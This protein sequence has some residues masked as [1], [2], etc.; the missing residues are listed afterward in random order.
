MASTILKITSTLLI[1]A[2]TV[3]SI[4]VAGRSCVGDACNQSIQSGNVNLGSS[5][6]VVPVTQVTPITRY[7]PIVQSYAPIVQAETVCGNLPF[8]QDPGAGMM[9]NRFRYN[10][11]QIDRSGRF[12]FADRMSDPRFN[13]D[14]VQFGGSYNR[15]YPGNIN[16][17]N[18]DDININRFNRFYLDDTNIHH[19]NLGDVNINRLNKRDLIKSDEDQLKHG[20]KPECVPSATET[21]EQNLPISTTDMGSNVEVKPSNVI[22]PSTVYQ[23]HVQSVAAEID[24][25]PAQQ[26]SLS[27][28]NVNLG[29]NTMIQ[30]V[31]KVFPETTFQ[32]SVRQK[33]TTIQAA[34][35]SDQSLGRS[36][37]SLGSSVTIRPTTTVEPLTVYQPRI[38]SLPFLI[39]DEGCV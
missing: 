6:N 10:M 35:V 30:P 3:Q 16:R 13:S 4:P 8:R 7:Q 12:P 34:E 17:I 22:L 9:M 27:R 36:S 2:C 25:A 1:V 29:S 38:K 24:A 14:M 5:T 31:T 28:S 26:S 21:C 23:G 18:I 15:F 33:A 11:N 19:L 39:I 32:P 20:I 37:V